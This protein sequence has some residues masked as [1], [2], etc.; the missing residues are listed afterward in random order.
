MRRPNQLGDFALEIVDDISK[1]RRAVGPVQDRSGLLTE[2]RGPDE[3]QCHHQ[4]M[5]R[6]GRNIWVPL[7]RTSVE[8]CVEEKERS[9]SR[10]TADQRM[11]GSE[12]CLYVTVFDRC[13][14]ELLGA[15]ISLLVA[16]T[17]FLTL[18]AGK[19]DFSVTDHAAHLETSPMRLG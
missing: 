12:S 15:P 17:A 4:S 13:L 9:R 6:E 2:S 11:S 10:V 5:P 7:E 8:G 19:P 1:P 18:P 16:D 14:P 3:V